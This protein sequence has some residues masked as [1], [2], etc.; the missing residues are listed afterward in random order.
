MHA[1]FY[2]SMFRCWQLVRILVRTKHPCLSVR[3]H[4]FLQVSMAPRAGS[5]GPLALVLAP[6]AA[7]VLSGAPPVVDGA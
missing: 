5:G 1:M 4:I 2:A 6:T 7:M 3:S